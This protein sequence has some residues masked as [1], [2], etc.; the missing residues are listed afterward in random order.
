MVVPARLAPPNGQELEPLDE[1]RVRDAAIAL[2]DAS[3]ESVAIC[4]LF[5]YLNPAHEERAKAIVSEI[6]PDA[7]VTTSSFIS[8]QFREFE[9]FTTAALGA[10]TGQKVRTY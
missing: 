3:V 4:F 5:S 10:F 7:F 1:R 6:L 2:R 9:R 8:T